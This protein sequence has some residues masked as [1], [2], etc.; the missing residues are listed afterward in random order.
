M[1][2]CNCAKRSRLGCQREA[3]DERG[4]LRVLIIVTNNFP[5]ML[6]DDAVADTQTQAR[7]LAHVFGC[8]EWIEDNGGI[9]NAGTIIAEGNLHKGARQSALDFDSGGPRGFANRVIG[10]IQ[11]VEKHLLQLMRVTDDLGQRFVEMFDHL[12]AMTDEIVRS[13]MHRALQNRI[14]LQRLAL[15]RHLAGKT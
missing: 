2:S 9:G 15:R 7:A 11:D 3:D 1:Y 14:E 4:S 10:I 12:N 6:A 13:Q 8:K 5:A